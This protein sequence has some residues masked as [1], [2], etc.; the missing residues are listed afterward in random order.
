M[1][2]APLANSGQRAADWGRLIPGSRPAIRDRKKLPQS[3]KPAEF[4]GEK[5]AE[6]SS[7]E[8]LAE[9][10]SVFLVPGPLQSRTAWKWLYSTATDSALVTV[11]WFLIA[12]LCVTQR[13][14]FPRVYWF[15][16]AIGPVSLPGIA[17]LHA[18]LIALLLHAEGM[19]SGT[20]GMR[21]QTRILG[22]SVLWATTVLCFAY[23]L[24]GVLLT[25]C[26]TVFAAG[27]LHF[28]A[29]WSWRSQ[30]EK[31]QRRA[32]S[33]DGARTALIVGAGSVGT[34]IADYA[35]AHPES[36]R[37]VCGFLDN[38][39][40]L[41]KRVIGRVNDLARLA[42]TGFV[43]EVILAAP[44]DRSVTLQVLREARRLRLDVEMVPELSGCRP[45]AKE[46]EQVG[47]LPAICLHSERLPGVALVTKR[48]ADVLGSSLALVML[49]P[50]MLLIAALIRLDSSGPVLYCAL[51]AGKKATPF[52]CYKFRTM[53]RDADA[54]KDQ[55]RQDNQ[56]S[57]PFFKIADD[58]R[59]T[60]LGRILRRY[61]LDELPQL[62]N[63]LLGEMSLVGPRPHTL[64]D[65]A[66]YEV[67]HL[68]RLDVVPGITGLWQVEAR[69]DPSFVKG[70]E[71]DREYIR[72]WSLAAD[73]R[74]LAKTV[75]VVARGSGE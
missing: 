15:D 72:T 52:R 62:W 24:Q 45:V 21:G 26:V 69:R 3:V 33:W 11:N 59:V 7:E 63:V 57:G 58:P 29:L 4:T 46:L 64:D 39:R 5:I 14:L 74:I 54:L 13:R 36:G 19:Y 38:D 61:S 55:L 56:R 48:V 27:S 51:R 41:G 22:K 9:R 43:D 60:C 10:A 23:G 53:V 65:F 17:F 66:A 31:W 28:A 71:L 50:L 30:K 18:V 8:T 70:M 37:T 67:E 40:P 75:S 1:A 68:A 20:T 42:R 2:G 6:V 12:A 32:S 47:D 35:E 49:S 25:T 16:F 34:H 73:L 44:Q